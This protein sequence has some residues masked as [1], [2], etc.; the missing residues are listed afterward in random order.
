MDYLHAAF[1]TIAD[2]V[3]EQQ[4]PKIVCT[5]STVAIGT[6]KTL[7]DIADREVP[8]LITVVS[9]PEF[10]RE[11][12]AIYDCFNPSRIVVGA[13][14]KDAAKKV[15]NLYSFL[16]VPKEKILITDTTTA[17][18]IKYASNTFLALKLVYIN[19][20][21]DY[22]NR[23]GAS[24]EDTSSGM[25][26]DERIGKLFLNAG[27]GIAGSCFPKDVKSLDYSLKNENIEGLINN[28]SKA[29]MQHKE[30]IISVCRDF[31]ENRINPKI[32][33]L[34]LTFKSGTDDLR[35]SISLI[36]IDNFKDTCQISTYDPKGMDNAKMLYPELIYA[37]NAV[38]ACKDA[39]LVIL[40]TEWNEFKDLDLKEVAKVVK[41]KNIVDLR[42]MLSVK[43]LK[44]NG[45]NYYNLG[46]IS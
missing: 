19:E 15:A 42:N 32:A 18:L 33:I 1:K 37:N 29:D 23:I 10:L 14:D 44:E 21:A 43:D 46:R 36:L 7:Q 3:K 8:G 40:A 30:L 41:N 27:P 6:N 35:D 17:E 24:I 31:I 22:C 13:K 45:F 5:K 34:G 20:L 12:L 9:N 26:M 2:T 39:D 38:D 4:K 25:G 16:N 28:I 11:G